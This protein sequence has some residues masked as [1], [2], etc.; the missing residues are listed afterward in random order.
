MMA[1][2]LGSGKNRGKKRPKKPPQQFEVTLIVHF[3]KFAKMVKYDS[4]SWAQYPDSIRIISMN[5][6][7]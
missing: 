1:V 7:L 5:I 4:K 2:V 6:D 3:R